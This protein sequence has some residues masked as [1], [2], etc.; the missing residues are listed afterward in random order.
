MQPDDP[1]QTPEWNRGAYLVNGL[2]HCGACH[3]PRNLLGAERADRPL[4]GGRAEGW[5]AYALNGASPA[6]IAWSVAEPCW[7]PETGWHSEHGV[8]RGP[9]APVTDDL[10]RVA[11][12]DVHAMSMY[13]SSNH[14]RRRRRTPPARGTRKRAKPASGATFSPR[15]ARAVMRAPS[16]CRSAVLILRSVPPSTRPSR[17]ILS[18]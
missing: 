2:G 8:A 1:G 9:M 14:G 18:W 4:A 12:S 17:A 5:D 11:E 15:A 7:L 6:P 16:R 10:G 3:T 13:L